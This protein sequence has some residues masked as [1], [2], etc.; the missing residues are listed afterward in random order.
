MIFLFFD[1]L[2]NMETFGFGRSPSTLRRLA[3]LDKTYMIIGWISGNFRKK[4]IFHLLDTKL[5][6]HSLVDQKPHSFGVSEILCIGQNV[7]GDT[8]TK[9][10][11]TVHVSFFA[12]VVNCPVLVG[13]GVVDRKIVG[14]LDFDLEK[15]GF[16]RHT[17]ISADLLQT[18]SFFKIF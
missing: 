14:R 11:C 13:F 12:R 4:L 6:H 18:L 10:P 3:I 15:K 2:N 8:R 9:I 16:V 7:Q 17:Y 5:I 1:F